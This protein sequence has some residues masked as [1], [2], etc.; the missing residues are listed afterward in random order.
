MGGPAVEMNNEA[1]FSLN[2]ISIEAL[3]SLAIH[4]LVLGPPYIDK[5]KNDARG[6]EGVSKNIHE[7]LAVQGS[8]IYQ[9]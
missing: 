4:I 8:D 7:G 1:K 2:W 9:N 6:G 5:E 3:L